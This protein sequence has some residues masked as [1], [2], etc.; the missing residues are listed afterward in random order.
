MIPSPVPPLPLQAGI[1][2]SLSD[3]CVCS[4]SRAPAAE[5]CCLSDGAVASEIWSPRAAYKR[6]SAAETHSERTQT[7]PEPFQVRTEI[8]LESILLTVPPSLRP[9]AHTPLTRTTEPHSVCL[10]SSSTAS[11]LPATRIGPGS[12]ALPSD[13]PAALLCS[14]SGGC[15]KSAPAL[16]RGTGSAPCWQASGT[17][18]PGLEWEGYESI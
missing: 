15:R 17:S 14:R 12:H 9:A 4:W 3:D 1:R 6:H 2:T 7:H 8:K 13:W 5:S 16:E 11:H 10:C 18:A